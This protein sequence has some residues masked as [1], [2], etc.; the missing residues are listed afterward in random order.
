MA[1]N[2]S[3]G[4]LAQEKWNL[5]QTQPPIHFALRIVSAYRAARN[6]VPAIY[7]SLPRAR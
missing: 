6:G 4:T 1:C 2:A 5:V 7:P 3:P